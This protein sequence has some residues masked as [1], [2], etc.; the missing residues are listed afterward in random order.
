MPVGL[1]EVCCR[2]LELRGMKMTPGTIEGG[3]TSTFVLYCSATVLLDGGV[4]SSA[5]HN[6]TSISFW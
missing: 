3:T 1:W 5:P 2:E 6:L 4:M